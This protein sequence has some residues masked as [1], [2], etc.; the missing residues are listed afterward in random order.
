MHF[1]DTLN[2]RFP[3]RKSRAQKE[4]FR[5][6]VLEECRRLGYEAA[7][8]DKGYSRNV[9]I[10][11]PET[12]QVTF[13]AHYDTAPRLPFPNLCTPTKKGVF[14]LIQAAMALAMILCGVLLGVLV[15]MLTRS[16]FV[17]FMVGDFGML[18]VCALLLLGPAN[19]HCVNDNTSGVAAVLE[20]LSRIPAEQRSKVACILFD[21]EEKG[22]LGSMNYASKHPAVKSSRLLINMDCVGD[23]EHI[24]VLANK[25]TRALPSYHKLAVAMQQQEGR[26]LLMVNMENAIYPSDQANFKLGM[27]ICA[28]QHNKR[29]GYFF[30]KIHT[31]KDTVCEQVN[32]DFIAGG[33]A[34]FVTSL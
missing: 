4:A 3:I 15:G 2:E 25:A 32:L 21:N 28:C 33:L 17:A 9:M 14:I 20:L 19:P 1:I 5:S 8:E 27:A 11:N 7:A 12:A 13:T 31:P 34:A 24:L 6:W 30:D 23:G 22:L 18:A 26:H 29:L 16:P 10:G